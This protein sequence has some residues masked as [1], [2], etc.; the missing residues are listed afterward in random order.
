M[1]FFRGRRYVE[2]KRPGET[3]NDASL[4]VDGDC[5][6]ERPGPGSLRRHFEG[7]WRKLAHLRGKLQR[8]EVRT[9]AAD[10]AAKRGIAGGEV[11]LSRSRR[12][13]AANNADLYDGVMYVTN[14]NT[15]YA[16]DA[17]RAG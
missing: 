1:R 11:G 12:A 6:R 13:R 17:R 16:L 8:L 5:L 4:F 14:A 3:G 2:R 15:V 7:A 10:Y 9:R